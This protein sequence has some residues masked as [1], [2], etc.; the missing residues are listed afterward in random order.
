M[1]FNLE[2]F[3]NQPLIAVIKDEDI[4]GLSLFKKRLEQLFFSD[5]IIRSSN[6]ESKATKLVIEVSCNFSL[7]QG[8]S[9]LKSGIWAQFRQSSDTTFLTS[10]FYNLVVKLQE[11]NDFLIAVEEFSIIFYDTTI[12]INE[13]YERSI[14]EQLDAIL[15]KLAEHY[16]SLTRGTLEVPY[17]IFIPVFEEYTNCCSN[18]NTLVPNMNAQEHKASDYFNFWALY[19][20]NHED[21]LTYA[22]ENKGVII[23][24]M[25]MVNN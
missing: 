5:V 2:N 8:M 17:E 6:R 1:P 25:N 24:E 11:Q 9:N 19:F 15:T 12:I 20:D 3:K 4:R 16:S 10:E 14:P 22:L 18:T 23:G 7:W 13:I 21:A